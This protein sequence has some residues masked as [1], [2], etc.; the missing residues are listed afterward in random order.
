M[1]SPA[2]NGNATG[3]NAKRP[4]K[5]RKAARHLKAL[6]RRKKEVQQTNTA[7]KDK[8]T[9]P[10]AG[11]AVANGTAVQDEPSTGAKS[12]DIPSEPTRPRLAKT[13]ISETK[14]KGAPPWHAVLTTGFI[15]LTVRME[16]KQKRKSYY[17]N[18]SECPISVIKVRPTQDFR[19]TDAG[20]VRGRVRP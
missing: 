18:P 11:D 13:L 7:H 9:Q 2:S 14:T 6:F 4:S 20:H 16:A 5:L 17:V 19:L 1:P 12:G 3:A 8:T 15:E 10:S